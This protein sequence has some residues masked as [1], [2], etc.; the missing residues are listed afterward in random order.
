MEQQ[1]R[2]QRRRVVSAADPRP[3]IV[4]RSHDDSV[5][6][7]EWVAF[8]YAKVRRHDNRLGLGDKTEIEFFN[9]PHTIN[10]RATYE[11]LPRHLNWPKW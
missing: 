1:P 8:E 11:F 6:I 2:R 3:F 7:D 9:G 4:E 10:G 5:G